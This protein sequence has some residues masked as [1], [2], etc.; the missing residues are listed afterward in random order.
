MTSTSPLLAYCCSASSL[1]AVAAKNLKAEL[2]Q[3]AVLELHEDG[4]GRSVFGLAEIREPRVCWR[5]VA[6]RETAEADK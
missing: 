1:P 5:S 2:P 3:A 4:N 6:G